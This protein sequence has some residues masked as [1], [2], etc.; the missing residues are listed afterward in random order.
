MV[1]NQAI[2]L[3]INTPRGNLE[4]LML[5]PEIASAVLLTYPGD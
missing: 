1:E 3:R 4:N 5:G 2:G